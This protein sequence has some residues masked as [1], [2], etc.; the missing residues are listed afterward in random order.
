MNRLIVSSAGLIGY[1]LAATAGAHHGTGAFDHSREIE[2]S[3]VISKLQF[4][5]PHSWVYLDVTGDDGTI[6]Q[7]RCEMRA[8][9]VLRRAGWARDM[10]LEGDRVTIVGSPAKFEDRGC[11]LRTVFFADRSSMDRYGQLVAAAS[12]ADAVRPD[13]LPNGD[14]HIGGDWAAEQRV[15]IDPRGVAGILTPLSEALNADPSAIPPVAMGMAGGMAMGAQSP[16]QLTEAGNTASASAV[17]EREDGPRW[18]CQQ[19]NIFADWTKDQHVNQIVQTEETITIKY[20]FMDI[21]RTIDLTSATHPDNIEP[22]RAG[23]S[24]GRW[25][26]DELIVDTVGFA[27]GTLGRNFRTGPFHGDELHVTEHFVIDTEQGALRRSWSAEDPAYFEGE[28][29]GQDVVFVADIAY[30]P[31]DCDDL[32]S[33]YIE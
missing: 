29:S 9:T 20:G 14:P 3:G 12:P 2:V 28:Y 25:E 19:T 23:H 26:R 24:I 5:N 31:Y 30:E 8:A 1:V 4:V 32:T 11:Y 10:F 15:D 27:P 16:V 6:E 33:E 7:W 22:S 13:R 17:F 18:N 21:V